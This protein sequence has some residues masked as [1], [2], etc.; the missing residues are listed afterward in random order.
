MTLDPISA[1][2]WDEKLSD[3]DISALEKDNSAILDKIPAGNFPINKYPNSFRIFNFHSWRPYINDPDY[4][5]SLVSENVL[6][7]LQ[8]ELYVGYNR[9]E[10]YKQIGTD[11]TYA[12]FFPWVNAGISYL[13]DRNALY[14]GEKVYWNELQAQIG[15]SIP[16]DFSKGASFTNIQFGGNLFYNFRS[17][18]GL[19]KDTFATRSFSFT[20]LYAN[21]TH[22]IQQAQQ[23]IYPRFA[24]SVGISYNDGVSIKDARQFLVSGYFY[25]PGLWPVHSLVLGVAFQQRDSLNN[26]GFSN[27][28]PFSRGYSS[29]NFFS[30]TRLAFNYHFPI[31]YPDAGIADLVYCLRI[32]ADVFYDY[33]RVLDPYD[34]GVLPQYRSFGTE[35]Y[36]DTKWWNVLAISFGIRYSRLIDLDYEGRGPNQ[37]EFILPINLL[38]R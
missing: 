23:Q 21:F 38:S 16:L 14:H 1:G 36:F 26:G 6:S 15:S 37:W 13:F 3:Q 4:T 32:R 28:F 17:Y 8:S 18:Q 7:T 20:N 27:S 24:Q 30:M 9:N 5:F 2:Q 35:L 34:Q 29:E 11:A 22:Q 10:G 12:G 31:I 19:Y 33:T 25:F